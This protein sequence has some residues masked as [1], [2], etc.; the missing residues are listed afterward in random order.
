[1][2]LA[3]FM[4]SPRWKTAKKRRLLQD[5]LANKRDKSSLKFHILTTDDRKI[6]RGNNY[7]YLV[8]LLLYY[9]IV[10]H[11]SDANLSFFTELFKNAKFGKLRVSYPTRSL[12]SALLGVIQGSSI[13]S[14]S[15]WYYVLWLRSATPPSPRILLWGSLVNLPICQGM[16]HRSAIHRWTLGYLTLLCPLLYISDVEKEGGGA[17]Q[18]LTDTLCRAWSNR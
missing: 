9:L 11:G 16:D 10:L 17:W 5:K 2:I 3:T 14:R 6:Y 12:T 7:L 13:Y 18:R 15:V 8:T 4:R 1:M